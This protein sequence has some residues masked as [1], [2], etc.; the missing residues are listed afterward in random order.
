MNIRKENHKNIIFKIKVKEP[1]L[2]QIIQS[3]K[4]YAIILLQEI[5]NGYAHTEDFILKQCHKKEL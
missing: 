2:I 5:E 3:D 4:N 1:Q